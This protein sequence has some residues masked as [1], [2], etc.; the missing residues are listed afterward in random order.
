MNNRID[1]T[2]LCGRGPRSFLIKFK[3]AR[4]NAC[5]SGFGGLLAAGGTI[6]VPNGV[7]DKNS[8]RWL[9]IASWL[10]REA[11]VSE[12]GSRAKVPL[13]SYRQNYVSTLSY[14]SR[15]IAF[16]RIKSL[17]GDP[18]PGNL[19]VKLNGLNNLAELMEL[20]GPVENR[21]MSPFYDSIGKQVEGEIDFIWN[22]IR[23]CN[24]FKRYLNY[25]VNDNYY[26]ILAEKLFLLA[27][28][29][30]FHYAFVFSQREE[31]LIWFCLV[32]LGF[33]QK[34][35]F[36]KPGFRIPLFPPK[37]LYQFWYFHKK[38]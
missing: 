34:P 6:P 16:A 1:L 24:Y 25:I 22:A 4:Y 19:R 9:G 2:L 12:P 7:R 36:E 18:S 3:L 28:G 13:R 14:E 23:I 30:L 10:D 29:S 27:R 5:H 38:I 35:T 32:K 26:H 21:H 31:N 11:R 8:F 33:I 37:R 15:V 20:W 17:R